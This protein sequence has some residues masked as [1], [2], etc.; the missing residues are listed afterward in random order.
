MDE[1]PGRGS[2]HSVMRGRLITPLDHRV[3][4]WKNGM[5]LTREVAI[6]PPDAALE[7]RFR[8]RLSVADVRG[9]GPFS[10]FPGYE[11]TIMVVD[12]AGMELTVGADPPRLL[13]RHF[14]PFVF[15][16]DKSTTCRLLGG[17][18]RDF[19]LMVERP[20]LRSKLE[21]LRL[22]AWSDADHPIAHGPVTMILHCF[23]GAAEVRLQDPPW[24]QNLSADCTFVADCRQSKGST[25]T[26]HA[27]GGRSAVLAV[28]RVEEE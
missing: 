5:G 4:P 11:R 13:D 16:G 27:P 18:I 28:I 15:S 10:S 23:E 2:G 6:D 26:L 12:G 17:P 24:T 1:R 22:D 8:W 19:N 20:S 9:S 21:M 7:G 25:M 3:M 14:E